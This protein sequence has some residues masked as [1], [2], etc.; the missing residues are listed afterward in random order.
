M[1]DER[2]AVLKQTK[3]G[4]ICQDWGDNPCDWGNFTNIRGQGSGVK[5]VVNESE[6]QHCPESIGNCW[7]FLLSEFSVASSPVLL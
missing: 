1:G 4:M 7:S 2:K 3:A 5:S 6:R